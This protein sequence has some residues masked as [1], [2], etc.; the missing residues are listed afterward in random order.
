MN[1]KLF[2]PAFA[3]LGFITVN[4]AAVLAAPAIALPAVAPDDDA[5]Y[6]AGT[7]ALNERRWADAVTSFEQTVSAKGKKVDAALYWK[8]YALNKL[9]KQNLAHDTCVQLATQFK[10]STWNKDCSSLSASLVDVN[11][12]VKMRDMERLQRD[13]NRNLQRDMNRDTERTMNRD[14]Q[15]SKDPDTEIKILALNS[16]MHRDPAQAMP[17]M[18]TILTGEQPMAIKQQALFALAQNKSPEADALMHDLVAGKMG[19]ELQLQAIQSSGIYRGRPSND[20]LAE[21]YHNSTDPKVK[22]AVISAYFIAN[23]DTRLVE[24][25]RQEKD[26]EMKRR[27][28]SQL[29]LMKGKAAGDYMMELLK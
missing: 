8:A 6:A 18:R 25:A 17:I 21:A 16:L 20:G 19:P 9:G 23:D 10:D 1:R 7:K 24:L 4:P 5:A 28:V 22:R 27:I 11:V 15:P 13:Q 29:S 14:G 2:L 3:L 12:S 26:L